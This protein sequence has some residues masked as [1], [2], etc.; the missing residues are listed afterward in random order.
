MSLYQQIKEIIHCKQFFPPPPPTADSLDAEIQLRG[1][2]SV[3]DVADAEAIYGTAYSKALARAVD[4]RRASGPIVCSH[5]Q[6]W[7]L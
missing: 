5:H 1:P 7:A 2:K 6:H 3:K 4:R